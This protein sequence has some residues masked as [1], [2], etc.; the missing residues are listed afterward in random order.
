MLENPSS[1][2]LIGFYE[3]TLATSLKR[4]ALYSLI[5]SGELRPIKLGRK[6][7]FLESEIQ[8]WINDRSLKNC[9]SMRVTK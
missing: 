6:T 2:R 1:K 5:K 4:T 3:V 9:T 7:V 8:N